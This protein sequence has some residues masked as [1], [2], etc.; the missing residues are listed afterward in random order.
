VLYNAEEFWQ[1]GILG[2]A[3]VNRAERPTGRRGLDM[4]LIVAAAVVVLFAVVGVVSAGSFVADK[5][6]GGS[7]KPTATAKPA[8]A[9]AVVAQDIHRAQAQ[10]T[11][12]VKQAQSAGHSIVVSAGT[13]ARRQ[14]NAVI[15][16][17]RRQAASY[18]P[19]VAA[20]APAPATIPTAVPVTGT[21][22]NATATGGVA[23]GVSP[24]PA[25]LVGGVSSNGNVG[26]SSGA[27][28][29]GGSTTLPTRSSGNAA[30]LPNL[31][32]LPK[33]WLVV[34]YNA[35]FTGAPSGVGTVSVVN[36]SGKTFSG[37]ATVKYKSGGSSS[38]SFSG[39]APGQSLVLPLSGSP[40]RGGGYQIVLNGLH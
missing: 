14:A 26:S 19:P 22:G 30:P 11:A 7:T 3:M 20:A 36:R 23:S 34:G 29:T 31:G 27:G 37:V 6:S 28:A 21:T 32:S 25:G 2:R 12:I 40:Y 8:T 38:A 17:A 10:A 18:R 13:K 9:N 15:A 39:L 35:I 5:V 16:T 33:T 24:A 1:E 4:A